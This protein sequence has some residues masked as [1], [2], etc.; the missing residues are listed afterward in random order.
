MIKKT[1]FDSL[2]FRGSPNDVISNGLI[3]EFGWHK[4]DGEIPCAN[5]N[6]CMVEMKANQ[7][8]PA[9]RRSIDV[10]RGITK[11]DWRYSIKDLSELEVIS[12]SA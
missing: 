6:F 3:V 5:F 4:N 7:L 11:C 1:W 2:G 9:V 10:D 8:T 12:S